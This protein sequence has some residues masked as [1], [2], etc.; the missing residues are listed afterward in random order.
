MRVCHISDT[1][2][3]HNKVNVPEADLLIHSG[4]FT[5]QGTKAQVMS[6]IDWFS[7]L[8]HKHKCCIAGNHDLSF[9]DH[10]SARKGLIKE[11]KN[12]NVYYL[13][14]SSVVIEGLKIW[15]S[16]FTPFFFNWAFNLPR[17]KALADKWALI[18][19]DTNILVTH[20]PPYG[21]LD[22]VEDNLSNLGR[23]LH[24]GCLDLMYRVNQ[25]KELKAHCF[26]HLH[27][28]GGN[29][30]NINNLIFSNAAICTESYSPTNQPQ[31]FN[32]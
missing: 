2:N 10:H 11:F 6:F 9:E 4:D 21:I 1:H 8:P 16:P 25:L 26:G 5:T 12:N 22:L 23:D 24:Q 29:Q 14:D 7:K 30:L 20:G 27:L 19:D 17:G 18:P 28:Q 3:H 13:K 32:I 15:G 31:V